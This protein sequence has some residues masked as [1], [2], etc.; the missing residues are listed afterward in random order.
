M[1]LFA[2]EAT[3]DELV[4]SDPDATAGG[5]PRVVAPDKIIQAAQILKD[6]ARDAIDKNYALLASTAHNAALALRIV[7]DNVSAKEILDAAIQRYP[8]DESLRLQR[9]LVAYAENDMNK[10]LAL[11]SETPSE[12]EAVPLVAHALIDAGRIDDALQSI[13]SIDVSTVPERVKLG[14]LAA[15]CHAYLTRGEKD[16]AIETAKQ[17]SLKDPS[18]LH[19]RAVLIRTYRL[20]GRDEEASVMLDEALRLADDTTPFSSRLMLSFEAQRLDRD[21]TVV[22]LLK[23]RV[24]ADRES[25]ALFALVAAAINGQFWRTARETLDAVSPAVAQGEVIQRAR[26][27]L[28]INAGEPDADAKIAAY[29]AKWPNNAIM[30][31]ARIAALQRAGRKADLFSY[32]RGL[33]LKNLESAPDTRIRIA[34]QVVRCGEAER[35]I[36]FAYSVLMDNWKVPHAHL[37]YQDLMLFIDSKTM[38]MPSSKTVGE[39]TVVCLMTEDGERKYRLEERQHVFFEEE[40]HSLDSDLARLLLDR[41]VGDKFAL[42]QGIG[43]KQVEVLWIKPVY[44]DAFHRSLEEFNERFPRA[45]GLLRFTFDVTASDPLDEIR[46]VTKAR[47]EA[48]QHI[49]DRYLK[50]AIPLLF[51]AALIG[52]DPL[53]A[54]SG[55]PSVHVPFQVCRGNHEER[56]QAVKLV[57]ERERSGCVLDAIT[58]SVIRRLGV[59]AAVA[60]V[61]G[62]IRTTQS[63]LDLLAVRALEA[64]HDIG[65]KKGFLAWHQDQLI[66]HE[67]SEEM[68]KQT[69][70]ECAAERSWAASSLTTVPAMPKH[71]YTDETRTVVELVGHAVCGP[72]IAAHGNDLLLL[73]DDMGYRNWAAAAFGVSAAWLQPVLMV[74]REENHLSAEK[75]YE[76]INTLTLSGHTYTSLSSDC[77]NHE[78]R[79]HAFAV[80]DH[81]G[82]LIDAVG[83]PRADLRTNSGVIAK[84][85]ETAIEECPDELAAMRIAS[86]V[87]ESMA[88]GRAEN[89]R[90]IIGLILNRLNSRPRWMGE[91]A[92]G[93]LVGHSIGMPDF[94][95]L[96]Q[97]YK[98]LYS[99][100]SP[101]SYVLQ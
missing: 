6:E 22:S 5:L 64:Q 58:L 65:K 57:R 77:L 99:P 21:D 62:P 52:K 71:D 72:A 31:L 23:G 13:D 35:G 29:L 79:K 11:F 10:L 74:A 67:F 34:A 49:I 80:T 68:L 42:Q 84:F 83:G 61:C 92:F 97:K 75:Y 8:K 4:Q 96:L 56:A 17:E 40:R 70:E 27:V 100:K 51:A 16:L 36:K 94:Q 32:L 26:T 59:E 91:H 89:Q 101:D 3:L 86:R 37:A 9:A 93:W 1:K 76:A 90:D 43:A 60:T 87:F 20:A 44:I 50:T 41:E 73:S 2:A 63:V 24:A 7:D 85:L 39:D 69:A 47:A 15:R 66:L 30:I 25:E 19:L 46:E 14:L 12:P 33:T 78:A 98:D 45:S 48:D 82:R 88:R 95:E 18:D 54:W 53:D 55:L 81:L 38:T 28:A